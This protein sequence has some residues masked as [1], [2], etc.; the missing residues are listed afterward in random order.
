MQATQVLQQNG[1]I[2]TLWTWIVR[3]G[4]IM[5]KQE[6]GAFRLL[7]LQYLCFCV[8]FMGL[9]LPDPWPPQNHPTHSLCVA[10]SGSNKA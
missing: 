8:L 10:D 7:Y 5:L 9:I 3:R 2:L 1:N 6:K 4:V